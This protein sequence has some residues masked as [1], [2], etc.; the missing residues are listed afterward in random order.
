MDLAAAALA[1]GAGA[2]P[3]LDLQAWLDELDRLAAGVDDLDG[4]RHRLFGE[5][6]FA[7]NVEDYYEPANSFLHR[8]LE[9]RVGIPISLSVVLLEVGRR[10]G[11]AL[12]GV[13]MPGH[14]LVRAVD[15]GVLVDAF[16][17]GRILDDEAAEARFRAAT[18]AG[19]EIGFGPQLLPAVGPHD[20]LDRMLANLAG[21]YR[22]RN[23][24]EDLEW[25][26]RM[27]LALPTADRRTVLTLAEALA[28][29]GRYRQAATELEDWADRDDDERLRAAAHRLRARL[30]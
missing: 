4:L 13:G 19:P 15:T 2:E 16:G 22:R 27:R 29:R 11:V 10:A 28:S 12:E 5:R 18:G 20:I 7:G 26:M 8:V 24:G 14:F 30:N 21:I 6:G 1:I 9:R 23:D 17:G 25:V 3:G